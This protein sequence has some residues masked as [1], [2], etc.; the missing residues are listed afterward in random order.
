MVR[1]GRMSASPHGERRRWCEA[2]GCQH[3]LMEKDEG[4][5]P[6][7]QPSE[8]VTKIAP[9][10]NFVFNILKTVT[11]VATPA[12]NIL[13]GSKTTETWK[14]SDQLDLAEA[15]IDELPAEI[16]SF[17][18]FLSH[19]DIITETERSGILVLHRFLNEVDPTQAKLGIHRVTTYTGDYRW[20]CTHHYKLW[21]PNIPDVIQPH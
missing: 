17:G 14:I 15:I 8:L 9:Y 6:I 1:S 5:Y 13:F 21:Q 20:L 10:A 19:Q 12:I 4:S 18:R 3:P 16:D 2:E 11:P 7:E